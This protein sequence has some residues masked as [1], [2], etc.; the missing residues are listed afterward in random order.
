MEKDILEI[1]ENTSDDPFITSSKKLIK[2]LSKENSEEEMIKAKNE[3]KEAIDKLLENKFP[4]VKEIYSNGKIDEKKL[5]FA[6]RLINNDEEL[7]K[8]IEEIKA[9]KDRKQKIE[10]LTELKEHIQNTI[11][12]LR[13]KIER[14]NAN[15]TNEKPSLIK[16]IIGKEQT[17][18]D[19]NKLDEIIKVI[20]DSKSISENKEL[21]ENY[22]VREKIHETIDILYKKCKI[23][24]IEGLQQ[25]GITL[26]KQY[27]QVLED[28]DND[29]N[30][31]KNTVVPQKEYDERLVEYVYEKPKNY[32]SQSIDHSKNNPMFTHLLTI[33]KLINDIEK[34]NKRI[35]N[36]KISN[37]FKNKKFKLDKET[38]IKIRKKTR[39]KKKKEIIKK[40]NFF[41][42]T[43]ML[44]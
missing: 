1:L 23:K 15:Q 11:N 43:N 38:S 33:L 44:K 31:L 39:Q 26:Q 16:K 5:D 32:V 10:D 35:N 9:K 14:I 18:E 27:K 24:D 29:L 12:N 41:F 4:R 30:K 42:N 22:L 20:E 37:N 25:I 28:I 36:L 6:L 3:A 34:K 13:V 7:Y 19:N 8:Q 40:C 21:K 2:K 17:K